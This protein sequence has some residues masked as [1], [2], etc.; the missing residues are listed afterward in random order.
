MSAPHILVVPFPAQGHVIPLLELSY[1]SLNMVLELPLQLSILLA[2]EFNR[3]LLTRRPSLLGMARREPNSF[4][5]VAFGSFTIMDK[6][7][8]REL[9]LGLELTNKPFLWV[10]RPN[11][12]DNANEA[13]LEGFQDRVTNHG[14]MV[15]WAPQQKVFSHPSIA[16]FFSHCSW[17]STMEGWD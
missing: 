1:A 15:D 14:K 3:I 8:F 10:V 4:I 17:N 13:F 16:Y 2:R 6:I 5:Y 12:S 11:I 7:Q 9:A